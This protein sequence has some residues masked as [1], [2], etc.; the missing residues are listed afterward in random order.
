MKPFNR[1]TGTQ[2]ASEVCGCGG[3]KSARMIVCGDC[4]YRVPREVRHQVQF[5]GRPAKRIA[6]RVVIGFA[7]A[8]FEDPE[9]KFLEVS[10]GHGRQGPAQYVRG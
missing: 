10:E 8:R 4:W 1:L 6:A 5:G 3:V 9:V 7:R 2:Q